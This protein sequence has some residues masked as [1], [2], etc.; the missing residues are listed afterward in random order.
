MVLGDGIFIGSVSN[1]EGDLSILN[2]VSLRNEDNDSV[3]AMLGANSQN[4]SL[5]NFSSEKAR[6]RNC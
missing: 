6:F 2:L 3:Q 4:L 5:V 1:S